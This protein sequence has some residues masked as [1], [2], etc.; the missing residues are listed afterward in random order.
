MTGTYKGK[1]NK[2]EPLEFNN[3]WLVPKKIFFTKGIG[4][5]K[6]KLQSFELA[7]AMP[8]SKNAT[9]CMFLRSFLP[10][11]KSFLLKKAF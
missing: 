3:A 7:R 2:E 1:K 8:E 4:R 5:H 10:T 6:A 11:V 9:W